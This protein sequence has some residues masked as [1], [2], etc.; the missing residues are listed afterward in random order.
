MNLGAVWDLLKEIFSEWSEDKAARLAAALAYYIT[1]SLAP[2]LLIV[3]AIVG[4]LFGQEAVQGRVVEQIQGLVGPDGA[5]LVQT[6]LQSTRQSGSNIVAT[7]IGIVTL[8][9]G[10]TGVFVQLQDALN[11]IWEVAPKPGRGVLGMVKD[12]L[13][14][15]TMLLG[16]GFLLLVS[17]AVS[18]GL[19]AL[20]SFLGDLLPGLFEVAKVLDFVISLGVI[21]LLFA[22]IYKF[23]PDVKIRWGDVWVGAAVTSLLFTVG[24]FL[25]G[26]YLGY[27]SAASVYG[28]AGSLAVLL[29][30]IYYTAQIVLLGAEFTQV[31]A[32]RYG[33][34]IVPGADA[35]FTSD[36]MRAQQGMPRAEE[37]QRAAEQAR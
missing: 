2:L 6:M 16:I 18:A 19:A 24:K 34:R 4:L 17:L 5:Q 13:L 28:A 22:M 26:L 21:T 11:T 32:K 10:A 27:S 36:E 9:L 29:I 25:I 12:R 23:L 30:W 7:L 20:S 3:I 1:F 35:M 33:S 14:S 15:F 37:R 31:Y 8:L